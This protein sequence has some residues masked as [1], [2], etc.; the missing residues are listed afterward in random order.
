M[1]PH[2]SPGEIKLPAP[3]ECLEWAGKCQCVHVV[4][5]AASV[6][7]W[8]CSFSESTWTMDSDGLIHLADAE[9][10]MCLT[11]TPQAAPRT[12]ATAVAVEPQ[13]A[14]DGTAPTS[15]EG[16]T[17]DGNT[18][19]NCSCKG[20]LP[21]SHVA[22]PCLCIPKCGAGAF[23]HVT[24]FTAFSQKDGGAVIPAPLVQ[25]RK[26][27]ICHAPHGIELQWQITD[28]HVMSGQCGTGRDQPCNQCRDNVWQ[29]DAAEFY[30]A[31]TLTDTNQNVTEIDVSPLQGGLWASFINNPT[32]Y[33]PDSS[34]PIDCS[35]IVQ[36]TIATSAGWNSNLTIPWKAL[37]QKASERCTPICLPKRS[38]C[39]SSSSG[40][41]SSSIP[42]GCLC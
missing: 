35:L 13:N 23:A 33:F 9:N 12:A 17:L 10:T 24:S 6:E 30:M 34:V 29:S 1:S 42:G 4:Q 21:A 36:S 5:K 7:L 18:V 20:I 38:R 26:A 28:P 19:D 32:G 37:T 40:S 11:A 16:Q 41:S 22:V 2:G 15:H 31:E 14:A 8:D 27:S 39:S 25:H 3:I